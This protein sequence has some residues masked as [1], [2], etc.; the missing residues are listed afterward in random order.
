MEAVGGMN[1]G[2]L[3]G[4]EVPGAV[5]HHRAG[6]LS[7]TKLFSPLSNQSQPPLQLLRGLETGE[8]WQPQEMLGL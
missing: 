2:K 6:L 3:P 5:S 7:A 1:L 8:K 4:E